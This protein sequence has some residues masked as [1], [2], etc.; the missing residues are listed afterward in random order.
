MR[1]EHQQQKWHKETIW[2]DD[3]SEY[4]PNIGHV[5]NQ[6]LLSEHQITFVN[7]QHVKNSHHAINMRSPVDCSLVGK[8]LVYIVCV[9]QSTA[10]RDI[11]LSTM[12]NN[13]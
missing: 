12:L 3:K 11:A 6:P 13:N 9:S 5:A 10:V 4:P 2:I 1:R 7:Q 8:I